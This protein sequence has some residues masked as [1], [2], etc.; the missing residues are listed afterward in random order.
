MNV[1]PATVRLGIIGFGA[2]GAMYA[3][4]IADRR[5]PTMTVAAIADIDP[6][7][8]AAVERHAVP[9]FDDY[10]GLIE[11]GL[12]DAIVTTVPHYEHTDVA[13]AA[14]RHGVHVLVD[15]PVA[16]STGQVSELLDF[17]TTRPDL[18][19]AVMFNQ[20]TNPLYVELKALL[21]SGQ[22]GALRRC[23]RQPGAAPARPLAVAVRD[24]DKRIRES[25]VRVP[26]R[27][28]RG[29]RGERSC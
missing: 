27:H 18:T 28:R 21:D 20:R 5:V 16:V 23:A 3:K 9:F 8:R 6:K 7:R 2:Q 10:N 12:V 15:K 26:A 19:V 22:L 4:L 1:A 17:A 25:G 24:P 13:I 29:G 14:L 11:S